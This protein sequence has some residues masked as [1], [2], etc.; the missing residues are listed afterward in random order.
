MRPLGRPRFLRSGAASVKAASVEVS[1]AKAVPEAEK[2][3]AS[4]TGTKL[5]VEAEEAVMV[6]SLLRVEAK[7]ATQHRSRRGVA[8]NLWVDAAP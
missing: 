7:P 1:S 2:A 3:V 6:T 8:Q 5:F 4:S